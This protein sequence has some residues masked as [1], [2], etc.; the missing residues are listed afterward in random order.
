MM[1]KHLIIMLVCCLIPVVALAAIFLLNVQVS[2]V[3]WIGLVLLCPLSHLFMMK[4]MMQDNHDH[5]MSHSYKPLSGEKGE[6][7]PHLPTE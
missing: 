2:S 6:L 7:E 3:L 1:K 4:F 5:S